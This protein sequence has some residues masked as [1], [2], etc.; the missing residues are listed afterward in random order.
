MKV[1]E[2]IDDEP[3]VINQDCYGEGWLVE[4]K[5]EGSLDDAGLMSAEDY[6]AGLEG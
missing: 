2:A 4:V 5:L 1:N 3:A 6:Q